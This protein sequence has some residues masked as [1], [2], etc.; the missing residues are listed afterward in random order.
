MFPYYAKPSELL[1]D[2]GVLYLR[3][4]NGSL[5]LVGAGPTRGGLTF[6]PNRALRN[7][8]FDGKQADIEGLDRPIADGSATLVGSILDFS[9]KSLGYLEP[10]STSADSGSMARITPLANSVFV[11]GAGYLKDVLWIRKMKTSSL[12]DVIGMPRA[13]VTQYDQVGEEKGEVLANITIAARI[14]EDAADIEDSGYRFFRATSIDDL[15]ALFPGFWNMTGYE[16]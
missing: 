4:P 16:G 9:R 5:A 15:D 11:Q 14:P 7:V 2:A 12:I 1:V 3:D 10:G 8:P 6:N 13:I